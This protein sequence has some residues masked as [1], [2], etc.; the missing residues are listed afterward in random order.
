VACQ[1]PPAAEEIAG[2]APRGGGDLG[3]GEHAAA[4]QDGKVRGGALLVCGCAAVHGLQRERLSHD[5]RA[6]V[7]GAEGGE[8]VPGQQTCGGQDDRR[9]GGS[10]GLAQRLWGRGQVP[11]PQGFTGLIEDAHVHGAGVAIDPPV[12]LQRHF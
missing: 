12:T 6:T 4:P 7:G 2:G 11:V 5:A 10:H 9:T 3:W 8:P 1:R